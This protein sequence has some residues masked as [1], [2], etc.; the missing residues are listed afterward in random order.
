MGFRAFGV[1]G[2]G[3][4]RN[5]GAVGGFVVSRGLLKGL[6]TDGIYGS[7]RWGYTGRFSESFTVLQ[8]VGWLSAP[9]A[10]H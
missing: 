8:D 4:L 10:R 6:L 9:D 1:S 5:L 3:V 7:S 2:F